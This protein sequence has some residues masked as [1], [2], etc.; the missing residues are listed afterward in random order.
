M[1]I[2]VQHF[3]NDCNKDDTPSPDPSP[4]IPV[5][6]IVGIVIG[7]IAAIVGIVTGVTYYMKNK[8]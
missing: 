1:Y 8:Q 4:L 7:F 5:G 2:H 6:G 3:V